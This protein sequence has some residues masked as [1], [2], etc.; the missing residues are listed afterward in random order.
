MTARPLVGVFLTHANDLLGADL[1]RLGEVA[2]RLD[3]AGVDYLT[4]AD[5]VVLGPDL[6]AHDALGG[7]LGYPLTEPY[8]EPLVTL[9]A[10]AA[11]TTRIRLMTGVLVA[12][13]RPAVLLAKSVATLAVLSGGRLELGVGSGWQE[14]EFAALG[15][16][17]TEKVARLDAGLAAC[18]ALWRDAPADVGSVT[19]LH[20]CPQPP[21]GTV[22]VW[23]AG[24]PTRATLRRVAD[25]GA[26][27]LP[28]RPLD[29]ATATAARADLD[30]ACDEAGRDPATVGIRCPLAPTDDW[31]ALRETVARLWES[32]VDGVH[33]PLRRLATSLT[34]LDAVLPRLTG[35]AA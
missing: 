9:A 11:V 12:P 35:L 22:P 5:H 34:E 7:A 3:E 15:V 31:D 6:S 26:G 2:R 24:R 19:G 30:R 14:A 17:I 32:G 10:I 20:C 25:T 28:I 16:P 29:A 21:G 18:R 13:L 27:W 8:P 4:V 33:L 1:A 23:F